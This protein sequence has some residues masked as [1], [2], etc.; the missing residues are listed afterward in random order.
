MRNVLD[1]FRLDGRVAIITGGA[2]FLGVQHAE[3]IAEV[4][5][6]PV[7]WDINEKL[8]IEKAGKIKGIFGIDASGARIDITDKDNV[9]K[10]LDDVLAKYGRV[11]ILI[12]NAANDPKVKDGQ[13]TTWS[14]FE[15]YSLEMW[16]KDITVG[17]TGAFF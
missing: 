16:E 7:L 10:G 4:G 12:N 3:A 5:G 17:L 8:A 6:I 14:R 13:N 1:R 9:K 11:D 15:N 2:G